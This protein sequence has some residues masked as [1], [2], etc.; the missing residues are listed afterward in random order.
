MCFSVVANFSNVLCRPTSK[1][2]L[3]N[4]VRGKWGEGQR[5]KNGDS[6]INSQPV[7][8]GWAGL[9]GVEGAVTERVCSLQNS[10]YK[11]LSDNWWLGRQFW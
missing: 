2:L 1:T 3:G 9:E 5:L 11:E 7:F 10:V 4:A 6:L 8:K